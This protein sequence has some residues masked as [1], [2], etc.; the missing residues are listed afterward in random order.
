MAS[1]GQPP[2]RLTNAQ[3]P[4]T[5]QAQNP[6]QD[7]TRNYNPAMNNGPPFA[8]R[9][10]NEYRTPA[11][12]PFP[13]PQVQM[14]SALR[15]TQT[16]PPAMN[17]PMPPPPGYAQRVDRDTRITHVDGSRV[18]IHET[19]VQAPSTTVVPPL[20]IPNMNLEPM[21]DEHGHSKIK[22]FDYKK[23]EKAI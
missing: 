12:F 6:N 11:P 10:S 14:V 9:Q 1:L 7:I 2:P 18:N 16:Q 20:H 3:A 22:S 23:G 4:P 5:M 8:T 19:A 17:T 13:P 15:T 21:G